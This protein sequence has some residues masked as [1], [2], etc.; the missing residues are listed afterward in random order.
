MYYSNI[1][2]H[3][4][5]SCAT[6]GKLLTMEK[7]LFGGNN[8]IQVPMATRLIGTFSTGTDEI[9]LDGNKQ[10]RIVQFNYEGKQVL[11]QYTLKHLYAPYTKIIEVSDNVYWYTGKEPKQNPSIKDIVRF[12]VYDK[13]WIIEDIKDVEADAYS[14]ISNSQELIVVIEGTELLIK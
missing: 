3:L 2:L 1:L 4:L 9:I 14:I 12:D 7:V 5:F 6:K 13:G 11:K 8:D 10:E